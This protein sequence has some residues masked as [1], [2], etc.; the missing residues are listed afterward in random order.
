M[1]LVKP[2]P[3]LKPPAPTY[4]SPYAASPRS[5]RPPFDRTQWHARRIELL[6]HELA[7]R[8]SPDLYKVS[9]VLLHKLKAGLLTTEEYF[10]A[11]A[12]IRHAATVH[13]VPALPR[14]SVPS[15]H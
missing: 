8:A 9:P 1:K 14:H 7:T 12:A 11:I 5:G 6:T 10:E 4:V 15:A 13:T 3:T 2:R